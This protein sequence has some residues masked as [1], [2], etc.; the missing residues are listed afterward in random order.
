MRVKE[1]RGEGE[2]YEVFMKVVS[3]CARE[4][5]ANKVN[6]LVKENGMHKRKQQ[7]V[8]RKVQELK[9]KANG[10][11]GVSTNF[12]DNKKMFLEGG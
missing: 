5:S 8:M 4:V 12:R 3:A 9:K 11:W 6:L 10:S 1:A 7:D 2:E